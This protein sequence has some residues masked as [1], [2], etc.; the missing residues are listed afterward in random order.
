MIR[1]L[2]VSDIPRQLLLGHLQGPD[3]VQTHDNVLRGPSGIS[4]PE[5]AREALFPRRCKCTWVL[6]KGNRLQALATVRKRSGPRV[7]ELRHLYVAPIGWDHC[8]DLLEH[9]ASYSGEQGAE[10]LFLRLPQD[11]PLEEI[12]RRSGFFPCVT[13]TVYHRSGKASSVRLSPPNGLRPLTTS[14]RYELFR[15]YNASTPPQVRSAHGLTMDQWQDARETV[16]GHCREF[17]YAKEDTLRAWLHLTMWRHTV[18]AEMMVHPED[19]D[20]VPLL[21]EFVA[22]LTPPRHRVMW[23]VPAYQVLAQ[24]TLVEAGFAEAAHYTVLV[25]SAAAR[26]KEAALAPAQV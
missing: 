3:L 12:A 1:T 16:R 21:R 8:E 6:V 26:V 17:V 5:L 22:Q 24:H 20:I 11:S 18:S 2:R 10:R 14:D 23:L 9:C 25:K 7:W 4:Y 13:E 15:L 19:G